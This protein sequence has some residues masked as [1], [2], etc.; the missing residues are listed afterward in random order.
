MSEESNISTVAR[1]SNDDLG[2]DY[3]YWEVDREEKW[4]KERKEK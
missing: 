4:K 2:F 3:S 1:Q